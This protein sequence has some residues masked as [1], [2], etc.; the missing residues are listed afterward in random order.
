MKLMANINICD[1]CIHNEVCG[2]KDNNEKIAFCSEIMPKI[3]HWIELDSD[4]PYQ[5]MCSVCHRRVDDKESYCPSCGVK[6]IE[7]REGV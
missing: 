2:L 7:Q 6:M 5:Y 3:G 1:R 4:D